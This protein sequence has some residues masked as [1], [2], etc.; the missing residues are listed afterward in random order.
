MSIS[1]FHDGK[2]QWTEVKVHS[3]SLDNNQQ[4]NCLFGDSEESTQTAVVL[5]PTVWHKWL[6]VATA[7]YD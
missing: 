5:T 6:S 3:Y 4:F 2:G 7:N 1:L